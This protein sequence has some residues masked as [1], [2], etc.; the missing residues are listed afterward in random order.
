MV[1]FESP[2][3][4]A[5]SLADLATA[6]GP[7]RRTVVARELT[8]LHEEIRRGTA[9]ELAA[10]AASGVRGEICIVVAGAEPASA[11]LEDGIAQVLALVAAGGRLK[12]A[13]AEVAESTGL[14]RRDL[15]QGALERK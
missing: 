12:E 9:S 11:S 15:Y 3:R 14:G 2:N 7:D 8:K 6:L 1:F 10:W 13:A 5:D 4:L